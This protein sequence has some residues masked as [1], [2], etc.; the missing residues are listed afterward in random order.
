MIKYINPVINHIEDAHLYRIKGPFRLTCNTV[1]HVDGEKE[2]RTIWSSVLL[3][4]IFTINHFLLKST[5]Q[6][7]QFNVVFAFNLEFGVLLISIM[8]ELQEAHGLFADD[9]K[10]AYSLH[11]IKL[12]R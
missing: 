3:P 11:H 8:N 9:F 2:P 7:V 10:A 4:Y 5:K 6:F 12:E 1:K